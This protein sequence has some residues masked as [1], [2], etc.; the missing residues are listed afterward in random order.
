LRLHPPEVTAL[1]V[2]GYT[3]T[4]QANTL[5]SSQLSAQTPALLV[6]T[7]E[8]VPE[9]ASV[10]LLGAGFAGL[11]MTRRRA[12]CKKNLRLDCREAMLI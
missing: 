9:S 12:Q 4:P 5:L 6:S 10:V 7:S 8:T 2:I 11:L 1:D 3:L